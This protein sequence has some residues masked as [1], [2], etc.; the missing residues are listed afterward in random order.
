MQKLV[1]AMDGEFGNP[2]NNVRA[3]VVTVTAVDLSTQLATIKFGDA[4]PAEDPADPADVRYLDSYFPQVDDLAYLGKLEGASVLLGKQDRETWHALSLPTGYAA[5][6]GWTAPGYR[7]DHG[8][9][10]F[11]GACNVSASNAV[12]TKFTLPVGYRPGQSRAVAIPYSNGTVISDHLR[13]DIL[14]TGNMDTK[15][16]T[17]AAT[18]FLM[19]EGVSVDVRNA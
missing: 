6:G 8:Q 17:P 3:Q 14:S 16:I 11:R 10:Q 7:M 18:I 5:V 4:D 19:F 12:G 15:V 2:Y 13:F 9:V 1:K